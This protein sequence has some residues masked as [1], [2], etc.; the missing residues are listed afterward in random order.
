MKKIKIA[1]IL[2]TILS[3]T[4]VFAS[5]VPAPSEN[6]LTIPDVK[7]ITTEIRLKLPRAFRQDRSDNLRIRRDGV[8]NSWRQGKRT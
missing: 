1:I 5:C 8:G 3:F 7:V 6:V 2:I 4:V